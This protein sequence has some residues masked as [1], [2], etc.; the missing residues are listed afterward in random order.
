M[1]FATDPQADYH[2]QTFKQLKLPQSTISRKTFYDCTFVGGVF[3]EATFIDCRFVECA[4]RDGDWAL[5]RVVGSSFSQVRF[6]GCKLIGVN[7]TEANWA[8]PMNSV[9]FEGC[10]L[11]HS[12]FFGLTLKKLVMTN[13]TAHDVD[14]AE[15]DLTQ[16]NFTYTDLATS[17][18]LHTNL[19]QADFTHARNYAINA[20]HNTLKKTKFM[21]PE[22]LALLH[23]LDIVLS[24]DA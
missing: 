8:S 17:R 6:V 7:W 9:V 15:A 12:T 5:W 1:D 20:Q 23:S 24:G 18:F 19:T 13:C 2:D 14:F 16:A 21:L 11:S 22:A 4:F 3:S 10:N